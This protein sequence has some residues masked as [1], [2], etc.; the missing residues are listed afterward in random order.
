MKKKSFF[1]NATQFNN[2]PACVTIGL[3]NDLGEDPGEKIDTIDTT[4]YSNDLFW[5]TRRKL[6][7]GHQGLPGDNRR[8]PRQQGLRQQ[9]IIR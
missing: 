1:R 2:N 6:A 9:S 4:H 8:Q 7:V 5:D 3:V